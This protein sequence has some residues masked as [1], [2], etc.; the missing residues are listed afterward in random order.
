[1]T[2]ATA[3]ISI[4]RKA[5]AGDIFIGLDLGS[6]AIKGVAISA[7]GQIMA[8]ATT[9][10]Q[11]L[12]A[13]DETS[14]EIAPDVFIDS[15]FSLIAKLS[16]GATRIRG[17]SWVSASGNILLLD[18]DNKP[19]AP[20]ISWLDERPLDGSIEDDFSAIDADTVYQTVGWPLSMQFPF[21]RLLWLRKNKNDLLDRCSRICTGNDWLGYRLTGNWAIDRSTGTTMYVYDQVAAKP[22][23]ANLARLGLTPEYFSALHESGT[24]FGK[25][26]AEA[27]L[28]AGL[29]SG[30][31]AVLG[32]FDHP[33][34]ARAL[35]IHQP[36]QLLLSCG[37]S[38]V[39]LVVLPDRKTGI[40][41]RLLLDPY[42]SASGG[43]WCGM[44]SLT[45]IGKRIDAWIDGIFNFGTEASPELA[46]AHEAGQ[47]PE[48]SSL[49]TLMNLLAS[50]SDPCG[51]VPVIDLLAMKPVK[52][53]IL[54]LL[55]EY[56]PGPVFRGLMEGSAFAFRR[57]L[58][59]RWPLADSMR[60]LYMVGGP[61]NSII[62][63]QIVADAINRPLTVRF[64][65]HAGS[66]GAAMMAAK[67][68]GFTLNILEPG[69]QVH[70]DAKVS[71]TMGERFRQ[72]MERYA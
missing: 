9:S 57:M 53:A 27:S 36:G 47:E 3:D 32:S 63:R 14:F 50:E 59:E 64:A 2:P 11:R 24:S 72:F 71:L 44:F 55:S 30:T 52:P 28:A 34:A 8:S 29:D 58:S 67:G 12:P 6:T 61:A 26:R 21:G 35:G 43:K 25:I 65:S 18:E 39:G 10:I 62:W 38:W 13:A 17:I 4:L 49:F 68:T 56:G 22:H 48:R 31:E 70:P 42:E 20:M 54:S 37:T 7:A 45:G 19:L 46:R 23:G 60:E 41:A 51:I 1:M 5:Q 15:I 66:V 69:I 16:A 40:D 33:G